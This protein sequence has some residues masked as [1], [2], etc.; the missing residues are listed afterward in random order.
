[1]RD[2][3]VAVDLETTGLDS[4][5]DQIIE[6]GA[7]KFR[8]D[9]ILDQWSSYINP[10]RQIPAYITQL[11]GITN[12]DVAKAPPMANIMQTLRKFIGDAPILGHNVRFDVTFL[13]SGGMR[14]QNPLIDTYAIASAMLPAAPRYSLGSLAALLEIPLVDAHRALND[15]MTTSSVYQE[16]WRR[17]ANL[18]I[19][20]LAEIVRA[21][22]QQYWDG[23]LFF[24]AALKL[25]TGDAL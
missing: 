15:A 11:T 6:I 4:A 9:E 24:E 14:L 13:Q 5:Q 23:G 20:V 12:A 17:S 19:D 22:K 21:G 8:E 7:V 10:G 16:L 2:I 18:P 3:V 25:R 1:M